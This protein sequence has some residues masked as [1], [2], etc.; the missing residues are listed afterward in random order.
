M[1]LNNRNGGAVRREGRPMLSGAR[2]EGRIRTRPRSAG[3]Q[4]AGGKIGPSGLA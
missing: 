4:H 3:L 1:A 2:M